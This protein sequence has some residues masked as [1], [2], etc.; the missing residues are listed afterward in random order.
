[1]IAIKI[2]SLFTFT[3]QDETQVDSSLELPTKYQWQ[4]EWSVYLDSLIIKDLPTLLS[5]KDL[6]LM[7][8]NFV[9]LDVESQVKLF[10]ELFKQM[11]KYESNY[12]PTSAS[13]DVGNKSERD[14]WSIGLL[15]LSVV[16]QKSFN[17]DLGYSYDDLL[18]PI[19]NLD[20]GFKIMIRQIRKYKK[21]FI[22]KGESGVYWAVIYVGGKYDKSSLILQHLNSLDV[23]ADP[24]PIIV[25]DTSWLTIARKELGVKEIAG[26]ESNKRIEEYL[27]STTLTGT[28]IDDNTSW[29]SA[30]A[31]W[32]LEQAGYKSTN[33]AWA[34]SYLEYGTKLE[35]PRVG[36]IVVFSRGEISGH[37]GFYVNETKDEVEVIGGNQ[38]NSV[39]YMHYPKARVIGYRWPV[40]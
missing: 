36:C 20:L 40:K 23:K 12:N 16:D 21:I 22:N 35:K 2:K 9:K 25:D 26:K 14:T 7:H 37:V 10:V 31:T 29:C 32:C 33:S 28:W 27:K 30:F 6:D 38:A 19:K 24:D 13:V 34:R 5:A 8:P 17:I 11:V 4:D 3:K 15:Q 18:T 39:C 1:M